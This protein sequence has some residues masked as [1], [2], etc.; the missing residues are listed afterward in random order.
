MPDKIVGGYYIK[1]RRI[2]ES[3]IAHQPP[4]Y[5][6]VWDWLIANANHAPRNI[7]GK[8]IQRGQLHCTIDDIRE[9]LHWHVGYR[10]QTYKKHDCENAMKWLTKAEMITTTRTGRGA[11]ITVLNYDTY[12][13]P[14]NYDNRIDN[15]TG[16]GNHAETMPSEKQELKNGMHKEEIETNT[17]SEQS[18]SLV[19][20]IPVKGGAIYTV[21]DSLVLKFETLF[22]SID[23]RLELQ[24][25]RE[26]CEANP[27]KQK[28]LIEK[29]LNGWMA[30]V[31]RR[32]ED[33]MTLKQRKQL[34]IE[35]DF[36]LS[37]EDAK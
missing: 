25:A 1:A 17:C 22:P 8:T 24:R 3:E 4:H 7:Y 5:R 18:S 11:I 28:V 29:F 32:A 13:N 37:C 23:V 36:I 15:R 26:W 16:N 31:Q 35:R 6:E 27:N 2:Q 30:R 9:G 20:L 33:K 19:F 12:Q 14:K 34:E 21:P 10:K